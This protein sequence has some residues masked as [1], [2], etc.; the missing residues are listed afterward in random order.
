MYDVRYKTSSRY[1]VSAQNSVD[2]FLHFSICKVIV[3]ARK[4]NFEKIIL[5]PAV[6]TGISFFLYPLRAIN[7]LTLTLENVLGLMA[8]SLSVTLL[9]DIGPR[10]YYEAYITLLISS[11]KF[12]QTME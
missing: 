11:Q 5:P 1:H 12:Y 4:E 3:T 9:L 10:K 2:L 7:S 8:G 6:V